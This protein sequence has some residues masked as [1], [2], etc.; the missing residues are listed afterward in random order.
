MPPE[1][2]RGRERGFRGRCRSKRW[3]SHIPPRGFFSPSDE[4]REGVDYLELNISE[5]EALRLVDFLGLTQDE[6]ASR[7]H[8]SRKT[9]WTDLQAARKKVVGALINGR[10]IRIEGGEYVYEEER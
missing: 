10:G 9:L 6:A 3:V 5:L 4:F 2:H 7:M 8:I 1:H